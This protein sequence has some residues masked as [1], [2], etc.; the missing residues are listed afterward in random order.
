MNALHSS[1]RT[2]SLPSRLKRSDLN[3]FFSLEPRRLRQVKAKLCRHS[4]ETKNYGDFR[5]CSTKS[6]EKQP[7]TRGLWNIESLPHN[8]L[9]DMF[10]LFLQRT[11]SRDWSDPPYTNCTV[12]FGSKKGMMIHLFSATCPNTKKSRSIHVVLHETLSRYNVVLCSRR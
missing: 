4:E 12:S 9:N 11:F 7:K 10:F 6:D 1:T 5:S 3:F 2:H 8:E